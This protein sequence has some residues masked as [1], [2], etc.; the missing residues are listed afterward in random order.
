MTKI[1]LINP[2]ELSPEKQ[3]LIS[4]ISNDDKILL[5]TMST[6]SEEGVMSVKKAVSARHYTSL[7]ISGL[8]GFVG[9]KSTTEA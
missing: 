5:L 3:Q 1:D 8:R 9:T 6:V 4:E 7:I 2:N